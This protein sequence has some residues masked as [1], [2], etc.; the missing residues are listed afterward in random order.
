MRPHRLLA[1][2]LLCCLALPVPA[3][4]MWIEPSSLAPA[5]GE[6][7]AVALKVG[8]PGEEV[9]AVPRNPARIVRFAAVSG[10]TEAPILGQDGRSPAGLLRAT[11]P[12]L[13]TLLYRSNA[14]RS[15]LPADRFEA[16]L[17]EEGLRS[18]AERRRESGQS[19]EPGRERYSRCLKALVDV[20]GQATESDRWQGLTL[21]LVAEANPFRLEPGARLPL[22]L[23]YEGKPLP[24]GLVEAFALDGTSA[25]LTTLSDAHGRLE[26]QLPR[27]GAWAVTATHMISLPAG[28]EADWES[29]W[30]ALTFSVPAR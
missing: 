3:H 22:R 20:G 19:L 26:L 29:F 25:D 18:I 14:A 23:L 8:H 15:E 6:L 28:S 2:V 7:L 12:G 17:A 9:E 11:E 21:E 10:A 24:G 27:G 30:T 4:D 13:L 16:Y 1:A 5:P